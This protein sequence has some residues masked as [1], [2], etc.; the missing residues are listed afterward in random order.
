MNISLKRVTALCFVFVLML[1]FSFYSIA[2]P[3][4][5]ATANEPVA[6]FDLLAGL[7]GGDRAAQ[8]LSVVGLV[9]YLLTHASALLPEKWVTRL[10]VWLISFIEYLAGN[11]KGAKNE[12]N[13]TNHNAL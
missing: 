4:T 10:P 7:L 13:R 2:E 5:P 11:Y 12:T 8:W 3:L 1:S 9:C 6:I